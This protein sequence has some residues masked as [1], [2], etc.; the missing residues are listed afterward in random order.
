MIVAVVA[1]GRFVG[2]VMAVMVN[3]GTVMGTCISADMTDVTVP[4]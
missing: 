4:S 3:A 2:V 1:W